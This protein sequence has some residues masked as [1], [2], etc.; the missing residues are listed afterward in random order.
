MNTYFLKIFVPAALV[1]HLVIEIAAHA[2]NLVLLQNT[3]WVS[4]P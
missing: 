3:F 4:A 2:F 1:F